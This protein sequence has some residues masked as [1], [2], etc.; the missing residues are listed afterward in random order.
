MTVTFNKSIFLQICDADLNILSVDSS[1]G[2]ASHDTFVWNQNR[3]KNYIINLV[4]AGERVFLLGKHFIPL[5]KL[6]LH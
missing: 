6:N 5:L 3:V 4:N 2:G 1:F